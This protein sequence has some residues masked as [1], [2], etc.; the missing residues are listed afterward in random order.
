[1]FSY[2]ASVVTAAVLVKVGKKTSHFTGRDKRVLMSR[3]MT[4][5][6]TFSGKGRCKRQWTT[7]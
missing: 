6:M 7:E 1:M 2:G 4:K 3:Y 5:N